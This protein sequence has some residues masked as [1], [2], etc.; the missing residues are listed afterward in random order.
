M[1]I[2]VISFFFN[3]VLFAPFVFLFSL[4]NGRMELFVQN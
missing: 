3:L 4:L 1:D 2:S